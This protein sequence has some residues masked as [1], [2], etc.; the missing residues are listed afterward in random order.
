VGH[1]A[2]HFGRYVDAVR[3]W[4]L[5]LGRAAQLPVDDERRL[6]AYFVEWMMGYP[7][8]YVTSTL[9]SRRRALHALG[10]AVVPQCAAAAFTALLAR[11]NDQAAGGPINAGGLGR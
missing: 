6:S 8:G 5:I 3:R 9:T 11:V 1:P 4:E 2:H 7:E 10:N